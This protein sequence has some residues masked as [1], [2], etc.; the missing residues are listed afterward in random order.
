MR[1]LIIEDEQYNYELLLMMLQEIDPG[2]TVVGPI[3]TIKEGR[4]FFAT[5]KDRI[6]LII[7]DIQ[8]SDGVAFYA[9]SDA[10]SD[11]PIIFTTAYDEYALRAFEYNSLSYLLK[12]I[13]EDELR[14]AISKA[15]QR[16]ISE[17]DRQELFRLL[18]DKPQYR[19]RFIVDTFKGKK[20][21][22]VEEVRYIVSENKT[23]YIV[24]HDGTSYSI[25]LSL[26]D[27]ATQ[28]D[29][30]NFMRV[31]RKYI[32]PAKVVDGFEIGTNGKEFLLLKKGT[33]TPQIIIS[34]ENKQKVHLWLTENPNNC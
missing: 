26:T 23:T 6:D 15:K 1:I 20:A 3:A 5:D 19:E 21:V 31:N 12:P 10:P 14:N 33:K 11:V 22:S 17:E 32:V 16:L 2:C 30:R 9:L 28:L 13:D 8:L 4:Q 25:S 7:S 24:L 29:P 18:Y 34:R 27:I